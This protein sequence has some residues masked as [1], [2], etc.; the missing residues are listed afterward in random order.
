MNK[1][2][3]LRAILEKPKKLSPDQTKAVTSQKKYLRIIAGAGAGKTETMTRRIVYLL[4]YKD[5]APK[6]IVAFTFT[7]RAAQSIKDRIYK[8]VRDLQG[9]NACV[10]LGEMYV[11]TIHAYCFRVL[12]DYFGFGDYEV[13]DDNQE[14]AFILREGW[15]FGL[16]NGNYSKN[17]QAFVQSANVVY[18][19]LLNRSEIRKKN[20]RFARHLE[21]YEQILREHRLLTFGQMNYL[22]VNNFKENP[23][24]LSEIRHLIVDEYQ[25]INRAQERLIQLIG[26][27]SSVFIVGDPRQTIYQWRGS[28]QLCFVRFKAEES[29]TIPE[30]RRSVK[31]IV[32]LANKFAK[33]FEGI[34]YEEMSSTRKE[35]GIVSLVKCESNIS[36]AEWIT[37]QIKRLVEEKK[38]CNYADIAILLRSV[39][40]SA[41]PFIDNFKKEDIPYLVGGKVGLFRRDEAQAVGRLFSW[42]GDKFW[43][44]DPYGWGNRIDG[45]ELLNSAID[46]WKSV[47]KVNSAPKNLR[48]N[49]EILKENVQS[50]KFND[51][52]AI[53]QELLVILGFLNFDPKDK[54]QAAIM[55]NLGRFNELL[56]DYESSIRRG[57]SKPD[58][59]ND[60]K[61]LCWYMNSYA[62][63][64]YE[65]QPAEDLRGTDVL[66]IMTVHQ[67]KGLE[68]PVVFVSCIVDKRFP[69]SNVGK[70]KKW[71]VPTDLF[72]VERYQGSIDDEKRLFYVSITR[73]MDILTI[74]RFE[75][76][77]NWKSP[78]IFWGIIKKSLKEV[79]ENENLSLI[80]IENPPEGEE[81][82]TYSAGEIL[83]YLRCPYQYRLREV[84][85]Y[86]PGL[87]P[88]LGFG[89]SLHHCLRHAS[90]KIK[91]GMKPE[92]AVC[93]A[94]GEKFHMPYAN[95]GKK[96]KLQQ[97][98][99]KS[100][101]EFV[102]KNIEDMHNIEEVESRLEFPIKNA[103]ITGRVDVIL[104]T[105]PAPYMEVRDYKTSDTVTTP[106]QSA[107]QLRLYTLG[108]R[109][110]G[111]PVKQASIAYLENG[112]VD[113]IDVSEKKLEEARLTAELC[114]E[115]IQTG[116][117]I[118]KRG[119]HCKKGVC[120]YTEICRYSKI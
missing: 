10:R 92:Q 4:L 34:K 51:F 11:G 31:K 16:G 120:D 9:D 1:E 57:G 78:S 111:R 45:N 113:M 114:I 61:G 58:W 36:E 117:F 54:L 50:G 104:K 82:R 26:K 77:K 63:G 21:E 32:E 102:K 93:K 105:K 94:V 86:Q 49:L 46:Y 69:S 3:I 28:D 25:D 14:M 108:L 20:E 48:K 19:E 109:L 80:K 8:R 103:T 40:T 23:Q 59:E 74:S 70:E 83:N 44:G 30:N 89:K 107:L 96:Q 73:A 67:A 112:N 66:Q 38:L 101:L 43:V 55:A 2:E 17:C 115:G 81:I 6:E 68:W 33:S 91:Q 62:S 119:K 95:Y 53:Y 15:A 79:D 18:D 116:A 42:L 118:G 72:E 90:E 5:I 47:L 7:E 99:E 100:L 84:W 87:S 39:S 13:L 85:G 37:K 41:G 60:L 106:E 76:M 64:A 98:G 71:Y 35:E 27:T 97:K 56:T 29:I 24:A 75:R 12:Q 52:T 22:T 88:D 110:I 65:E